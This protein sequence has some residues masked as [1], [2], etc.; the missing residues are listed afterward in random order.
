MKIII[1]QLSFFNHYGKNWYFR[2]T[3]FTLISYQI[4]FINVLFAFISRFHHLTLM[5]LIAAVF[6]AVLIVVKVMTNIQKRGRDVEELIQDV[7]DDESLPERARYK[8]SPQAL[9][10]L[11]QWFVYFFVIMTNRL[12]A[13]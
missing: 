5:I 13:K 10:T 7:A 3:F 6:V 4:V 1:K 11:L 9:T 8:S 2:F 12:L